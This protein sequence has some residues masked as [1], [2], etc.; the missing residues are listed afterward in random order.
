[1]REKLRQDFPCLGLVLALEPTASIWIPAATASQ[2]WPSG[3]WA[4]KGLKRTKMYPTGLWWKVVSKCVWGASIVSIAIENLKNVDFYYYYYLYS[5]FPMTIRRS[6]CEKSVSHITVQ[7]DLCW[8]RV[9]HYPFSVSFSFTYS[10]FQQIFIDLRLQCQP[11]LFL[12][13]DRK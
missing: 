12:K 3:S 1:M 13:Y 9:F 2:T 4:G 7:L 10:F 6:A 11:H 8:R 5:Y